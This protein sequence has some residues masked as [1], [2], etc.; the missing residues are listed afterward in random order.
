MIILSQRNFRIIRPRRAGGPLR[1]SLSAWLPLALRWRMRPRPSASSPVSVGRPQTAMT[2]VWAPSFHLHF[3]QHLRE[4]LRRERVNGGSVASAPQ[5]ERHHHSFAH[6]HA[7]STV[8]LSLQNRWDPVSTTRRIRSS[9]GS[10]C[11]SRELPEAA[12][13][14]PQW[15]KVGLSS[16]A[17]PVRAVHLAPQ[18]SP[19][20]AMTW[21]PS[22]ARV[23]RREAPTTPSAPAPEATNTV[24]TRLFEHQRELVWRKESRPL[25]VIPATSTTRT[26]DLLD[27]RTPAATQR[28]A[29]PTTAA[30]GTSGSQS[31]PG[32][33]APIAKL[34][35]AL[36]DRLA[37]D[38]VR[39]VER[40]VR[41]ERERRGL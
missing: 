13:I 8:Y 10:A 31:L 36:L 11:T 3:G 14:T 21:R 23:F 16:S 35:P 24:T 6:F 19:T 18:A 28:S 30:V 2:N 15:R 22:A 12:R 34:D 17:E 37:D 41:I 20:R 40:R 33:A 25:P 5:T 29:P 26:F 38:V 32:A 9:T 7:Q 4:K 39:R 27:E 1:R